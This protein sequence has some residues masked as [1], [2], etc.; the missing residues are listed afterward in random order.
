[1]ALVWREFCDVKLLESPSAI[2]Q[3]AHLKRSSVSSSASMLKTTETEC[4]ERNYQGWTCP[5][6]HDDIVELVH[7]K[8]IPVIGVDHARNALDMYVAMYK[9]ICMYVHMCSRYVCVCIQ[10]AM[11]HMRDVRRQAPFGRSTVRLDGLILGTGLPLILD[12]PC[13]LLG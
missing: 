4:Y 12:K 13:P 9:E 5:W 2:P 1:V 3:M 7:H 8:G 11:K 10:R 6:Q